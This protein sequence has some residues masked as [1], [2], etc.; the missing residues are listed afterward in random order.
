MLKIKSKMNLVGLYFV[1]F[2][3]LIVFVSLFYVL[4]AVY[5]YLFETSNFDVLI[6]NSNSKLK[7]N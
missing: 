5:F 3:G 6:Q 7:S 4:G 2:L 1:L